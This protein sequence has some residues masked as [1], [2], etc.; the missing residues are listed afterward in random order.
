MAHEWTRLWEDSSLV[1][2]PTRNFLSATGCSERV[3]PTLVAAFSEPLTAYVE[4]GHSPWKHSTTALGLHLITFVPGRGEPEN[5]HGRPNCP[6]VWFLSS[7]SLSFSL[8]QVS[9]LCSLLSALTQRS[10]RIHCK[11]TVEQTAIRS[12]AHQREWIG[13]KLHGC[14]STDR[15][16]DGYTNRQ[17]YG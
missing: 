1:A 16:I 15:Q 3:H 12:E 2:V 11:V 6:S 17:I 5:W 10:G 9:A 13:C 4:S 7:L 14:T 8:S